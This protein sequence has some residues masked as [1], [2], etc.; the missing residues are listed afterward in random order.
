MR[1][2][3]QL[4]TSDYCHSNT[5]VALSKQAQTLIRAS[6]QK[7][8]IL[9]AIKGEPIS[10][11]KGELESILKD[12]GALFENYEQKNT[13]EMLYTMRM[14]RYIDYQT[15][16]QGHTI[17]PN[18]E[19][20]TIQFHDEEVRVLCDFI[21]LAGDNVYVTKI[22]TGRASDIAIKKDENSMEAY[23]LGLLG[24]KLF[25]D[26]NI[27][28][29]YQYL[30][31]ATSDAEK[32]YISMP[33]DYNDSKEHVI[34]FDESRIAKYEKEYTEQQASS[35]ICTPEEC[36]ECSRN[37]ICHF[38]EPPISVGVERSVRP[39]TEIRL[40]TPQRNITEYEEGIARVNAGAGAG[41]TL[42]VALRVK[43]LIEKGYDPRK[44]CLLTFTK[45]GA[46]EMTS[47]VVQYLATDGTLVDPD[48]ITSTTFNAFCQNVANDHF[49]DLGYSIPPRIIPDEVQSGIINRILDAYPRIPEWKYGFTSNIK[50]M[51]WV[52]NALSEAK[53]LFE[54]INKNGYTLYD[55][56]YGNRYNPTSMILI[57]QMFDEYQLELKR[58]NL[59]TYTDQIKGIFKLLDINP[60]LFNEYG[61]EHIIVD[62]FQDSDREQIDIL[63]K[64]IETENF[65][66]FMA[67][68][69]DSQA[70]F[71]FRDTTPE[72]II[73]F[74]Q[75]FGTF[76]N[77]NLTENHR[78][79]ANI[80]GLANK[81]NELSDERVDKDLIATKED[82]TPVR[83][84]GFYTAK[85]EYQWIAHDIADRIARGEDPSDIAVLTSDRYE[86]TAISS[87]LTKLGVPSIMMNPIPYKQ[88]SRVKA[89]ANFFDSF[90]NGTTQGMLEYQNV[91]EHG[92]LKSANSEEEEHIISE[93]R[94]LLL[95]TP[96][97]CD[98][99]YELAK[100]LDLAEQDD[101]YQSF[102]EKVKYAQTMEELTDF[103]NDFELYGDSS[104][105]KRE[106][107]YEGVCLIT[108]H[109]AKGMEW[110]TTYLTLSKFDD[111]R[112]HTNPNRYNSEI[113]ETYRKWFVGATRARNDLIMTGQYVYKHNQKEGITLNSYL[114][115]AYE[116]VDKVY[117]YNAQSYLAEIA[118]E[119]AEE[120]EEKMRAMGITQSPV[121]PSVKEKTI[122]E[123]PASEKPIAK[124]KKREAA[125]PT[126]AQDAPT[127]RR[128]RPRQTVP[129]DVV[130]LA[131][132]S[133]E[134]NENMEPAL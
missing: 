127:P 128:R 100:G 22:R 20:Q 88:N 47:R 38:E 18:E 86:I 111:K 126:P 59:W 80:I 46:E 75:Y 132:P 36:A 2:S 57:F 34:L 61:Y 24:K 33:Y 106:G 125:Q 130:A 54:E 11:I 56:P 44:I 65:K 4:K 68:G 70:I 84:E 16:R 122:T 55:N 105:F 64:M 133:V 92:R 77:F 31:D 120:L 113:N 114:H 66:S 3:S 25:P 23:S 12:K 81:I 62:E 121:A 30:G 117:G 124:P 93:K 49:E 19:Q 119:K 32:R 89:L 5:S 39:Y 112:Y 63:N 83:V 104:T 26:K 108:V 15:H 1:T 123:L 79:S 85:K 8:I 7:N 42:V 95:N 13:A 28:I 115:K 101:C 51:Q 102:L 40:T 97:T 87:E 78:S 131:E 6:A 69:D 116:L 94:N 82:G 45:T 90:I 73:N 43:R 129:M 107:K 134:S 35:G 60:N 76:D 27:F 58:R 21:Q 48:L 71:S 52:K 96:K 74:G 99:F 29:S 91:V 109:S 50:N 72:F 10:D 37:N 41:K 98:A 67:V 53:Q 17:F 9:R 118:Q 103:F 110:N 14:I